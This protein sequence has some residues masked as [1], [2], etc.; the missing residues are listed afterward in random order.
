MNEHPGRPL[1]PRQLENL[2][3]AR[4]AGP[5][6]DR[7]FPQHVMPVPRA[8]PALPPPQSRPHRQ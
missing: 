1:E 6:L 5:M 2:R 8:R 7:E 3:S 4:P